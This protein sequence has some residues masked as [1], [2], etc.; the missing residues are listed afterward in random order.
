MEYMENAFKMRKEAKRNTALR[1]AKRAQKEKPTTKPNKGL[2]MWR[3]RAQTQIKRS[4]IGVKLHRHGLCNPRGPLG[5]GSGERAS[6]GV[7]DP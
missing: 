6:S 7:T 2:V 1:K 4:P 5:K 3:K